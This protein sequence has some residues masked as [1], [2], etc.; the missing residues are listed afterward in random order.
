M[1]KDHYVAQ[2]YLKHFSVDGKDGYVNVIRKSN[3]QRLHAIPTTSICA[4]TNWNNNEYFPKNPR[5]VE[6][7][8]KLF[9]PSWAKNV[10]KITN[11]TYDIKTKHLMS[12]YIAYLRTCTPTALRLGIS[13][14]ADIVMDLY[15]KIEEEELSNPNS[16]YKDIIKLI[17]KH[18]GSEVNV[19]PDYQNAM[20]IQNLIKI[21]QILTR[22]PWIV[23]R[24]ETSIPLLTSD[25][26]VCL[27]YHKTGFADFYLPLSPKLAIV[28]H[29]TKEI[30]PNDTDFIASFK[31]E[32]V[33]KMN[34]L[35]IQSAEDKIIFN[36]MQNIE[37]LVK[38]YQNWRVELKTTKLPV[39][40]GIITIHQQRVKN[41]R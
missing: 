22:S 41:K 10:Q 34:Q 13:G 15:K 30:N 11:N 9:E 12:G 40:N 6:D 25:N 20:G 33:D 2:T 36:D 14:T 17:R 4:K 32:G 3:L 8:L 35:M 26:P 31:P 16:K 7:F 39:E 38:K 21:H 5:I 27:Q 18:G 28:I 29:P 1:P 19:N 23:F 37:K 24:N